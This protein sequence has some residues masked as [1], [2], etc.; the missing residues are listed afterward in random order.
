MNKNMLYVI[1]SEKFLSKDFQNTVEMIEAEFGNIP[2][3]RF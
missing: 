3:C 1:Y 2:T